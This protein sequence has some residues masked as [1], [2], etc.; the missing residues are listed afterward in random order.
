LVS[1]NPGGCWLA[2]LARNIA[3]MTS[4]RN[5]MIHAPA[6]R[7]TVSLWIWPYQTF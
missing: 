3:S 1:L 7:V 4:N 5:F 6:S 2:Q